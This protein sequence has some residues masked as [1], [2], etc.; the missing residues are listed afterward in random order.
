MHRDREITQRQTVR[1]E[2]INRDRQT[3]IINRERNRQTG[4]QASRHKQRERESFHWCRTPE[5][6]S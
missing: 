6:G 2:D 1:Q 4:R 3:D 5:A